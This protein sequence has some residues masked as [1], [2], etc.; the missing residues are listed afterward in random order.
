M[1]KPHRSRNHHYQWNKE[2]TTV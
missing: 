2:C 1:L